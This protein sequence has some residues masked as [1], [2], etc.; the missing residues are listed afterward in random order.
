MMNMTLPVDWVDGA[1][2]DKSLIAWPKLLR[3]AFNLFRFDMPAG[4][5][6]DKIDLRTYASGYR[7]N[8]NGLGDRARR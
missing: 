5:E 3:L 1:L 4:V 6:I 7:E 2:K 8:G